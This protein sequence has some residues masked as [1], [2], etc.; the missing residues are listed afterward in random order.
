MDRALF[1][2]AV[3]KQEFTEIILKINLANLDYG[4]LGGLIMRKILVALIA[5]FLFAVWFLDYQGTI[6]FGVIYI[7]SRIWFIIPLWYGIKLIIR[8]ENLSKRNSGIILAVSSGFLQILSMIDIFSKTK[9]HV[10]YLAVVGMLAFW[11][12]FL[13]VF[14][15]SVIISLF[16][17]GE[18]V[19]KSIFSS[20]TIQNAK[21]D[22]LDTSLQAVFGKLKFVINQEDITHRAIR[23]DVLAV[24]GKVEIIIPEGVGVLAEAKT[25]LGTAH[26]LDTKSRK[27]IGESV[28]QK[29]VVSEPNPRLL[30]VTSSWLLGNVTVKHAG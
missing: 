6:D 27:I 24:F 13:I 29:P 26:I 18:T 19:Y 8:N 1:C 9:E 12:I 25:R 28:I 5:A 15:I 21:W 10:F 4:R 3:I 20:K 22:M 17:K 30:L 14:F 16:D 2:F 11:P 23:L 7:I